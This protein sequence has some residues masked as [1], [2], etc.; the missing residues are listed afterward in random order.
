[1]VTAAPHC[2]RAARTVALRIH[3]GLRFAQGASSDNPQSPL[4][5]P[6]AA[7]PDVS[8]TPPHLAERSHF[9]A[10]FECKRITVLF[11]DLSSSAIA[12]PRRARQLSTGARTPDGRQCIASRGHRCWAMAYGVVWSPTMRTTPPVLLCGL[13][14]GSRGYSAAPM[15]SRC[16]PRPHPGWWWWRHRPAHGLLGIGQTTHLAAHGAVDS[17]VSA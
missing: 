11:A 15:G 5:P 16:R 1:M 6:C 8:P 9:Q 4:P 10:H 14:Q 2:A 12:T 3:P 17:G 7:A 13:G